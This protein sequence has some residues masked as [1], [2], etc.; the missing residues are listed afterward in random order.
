MLSASA[1]D[2]VH[3]ATAAVKASDDDA[4]TWRWAGGLAQTTRSK[5]SQ[6][7]WVAGWKLCLS[8]AAA[9]GV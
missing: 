6:T 3:C 4:K 9:V 8:A 5:C 2:F 1:R 7:S